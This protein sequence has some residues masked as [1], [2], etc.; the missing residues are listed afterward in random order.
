MNLFF[1][2]FFSFPFTSPIL[3]FVPFSVFCHAAQPRRPAPRPSLSHTRPPSR[4]L[5]SIHRRSTHFATDIAPVTL[6]IN[7]RLL[8]SG[9]M[10]ESEKLHVR[11]NF[12]D[13]LEEHAD[14]ASLLSSILGFIMFCS[15]LLRR[16]WLISFFFVLFPLFL[17]FSACVEPSGCVIAARCPRPRHRR[18]SISPAA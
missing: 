14:G 7:T 1:S 10:T 13:E 2:F 11:F 16:R 5:F 12:C 8:E 15:A 3:F 6:D 17:L 18:R 4:P 9:R